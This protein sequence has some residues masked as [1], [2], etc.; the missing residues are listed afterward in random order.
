MLSSVPS[1]TTSGRPPNGGA[2][3]IELPSTA[4]PTCQRLSPGQPTC[5]GKRKAACHEAGSGA[6]GPKHGPAAPGRST[7][8]E[9]SG[10][11]RRR[12]CA[13]ARSRGR[14]RKTFTGA[15]RSGA[16]R[17]LQPAAY[18]RS[19]PSLE[20]CPT[21]PTMDLQGSPP[22]PSM[23]LW[24]HWIPEKRSFSSN[25][26]FLLLPHP[27][28]SLCLPPQLPHRVSFLPAPPP[29]PPP[30]LTHLHVPPSSSHSPAGS[31]RRQGA[32]G[33]PAR[34]TTSHC[35]PPA[36]KSPAK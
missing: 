22:T 24:T 10:L 5:D 28:P 11:V 30:H 12:C 1:G 15:C 26:S 35:V 2:P 18:Q 25:P 9:S 8:F 19:G 7:S 16:L 32:A 14:D 4:R 27:G 17:G 6:A 3:R 20:F 34:P 29:P 21:P 33:A 23:E 13:P 36:C 31:S